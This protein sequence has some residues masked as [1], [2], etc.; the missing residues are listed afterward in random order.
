MMTKSKYIEYLVSTPRNYT[1]TN[2][3]AHSEGL[4][5]DA[6]SDYLAREHLSARQ[7]WEQVR[8]LIQDGPA[9]VLIVD[10]SV[11]NKRHSRAIE[12]V[13]PQ[14]S[15]AEHR[16]VDG[17]GVVSLVHRASLGAREFYPIDYR[18][19]APQADGKTKNDHFREMLLRAVADKGLQAKTLLFDSW[20]AGA[21]NLKLV[22]RLRRVFFTTLKANR[23]VSLSPEAGYLHLEQVDWTAER[24]QHGV[25]VK[26]KEVPFK[27]RLFKLVAPDG[28]IDWV[29]TNSPEEHLAAP[30][31]QDAKNGRWPIEELQRDLKQLTGSEKCQC[32]QARSQRTHLACCYQAWLALK[33]KAKQLGK[34]LYALKND[35]YG[36]WL[37]AEL[38]CPTIPALATL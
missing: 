15:G 11:Q 14:H 5:H 34:S 18:L 31:V 27:V 24:L 7:L 23:L 8:G 4:S 10:D 21:Q 20:Y 9:G 12:L 32:R 1:C 19:Y 16:L 29:V 26:L 2:L 38:R 6:V 13:R 28:D 25:V 35:L 33:V 22:Q 3:A 17:I 36:D 30:A 37:R